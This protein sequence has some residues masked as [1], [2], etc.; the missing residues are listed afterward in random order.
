MCCKHFKLFG[1]IFALILQLQL[2]RREEIVWGPFAVI[3][4]KAGIRFFKYVTKG[5]DPGVR[6]GDDER[7]IFSQLLTGCGHGRE[8]GGDPLQ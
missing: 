4:A 1:V 8:G 5:L 7:T 6:R 2:R 3:P